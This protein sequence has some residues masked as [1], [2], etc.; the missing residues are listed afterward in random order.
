MQYYQLLLFQVI[1]C[2]Y[3]YIKDNSHKIQDLTS[4][5]ISNNIIPDVIF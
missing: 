1:C 5:I 3:L 4:I 2:K